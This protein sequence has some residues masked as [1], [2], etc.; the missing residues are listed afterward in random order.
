MSM[1]QIRNKQNIRTISFYV[2]FSRSNHHNTE[3]A[4][5]ASVNNPASGWCSEHVWCVPEE[6]Q[7]VE[8]SVIA[9]INKLT[10]FFSVCD[11]YR[12]PCIQRLRCQKF[13]AQIGHDQITNVRVYCA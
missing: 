9:F 11:V 5:G 12:T 6:V 8:K 13:H 7:R 2:H 3:V 10:C 4:W 1:R